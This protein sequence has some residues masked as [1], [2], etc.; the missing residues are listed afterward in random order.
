MRD[1]GTTDIAGLYARDTDRVC[2][3]PGRVGYRIGAT[4]DYGGGQNCSASGTVARSG[5]ALSVDLGGGCSFDARLDGTTIAFPG[6][7]PA[8]CD[9]LCTDRVSLTALEADLQSDAAAEAKV[10]R[11]AKGKVLCGS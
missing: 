8:A 10:L 5:D 2:I 3:V 4:V 1:P 9:K 11:D 7:M 6:R